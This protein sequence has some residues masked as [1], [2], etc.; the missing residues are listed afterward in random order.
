MNL[1]VQ[2]VGER[3][4]EARCWLLA[5]RGGYVRCVTA[6]NVTFACRVPQTPA[7][8]RLG[9]LD[10]ESVSRQTAM[11]EEADNDTFSARLI[12]KEILCMMEGDPAA[13]CKIEDRFITLA[14]GT[15]GKKDAALVDDQLKV[16]VTKV[17]DNTKWLR[18]PV[19]D[20]SKSRDR[21]YRLFPCCFLLL[22]SA[23]KKLDLN[24]PAIPLPYLT[25]ILRLF[26]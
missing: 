21:S 1:I 3:A 11:P 14:D 22:P 17:A 13:V 18:S 25:A 12:S 7:C 10:L 20:D 19:V 8:A 15:R 2:I 26:E 9:L 24:T 23:I 16:R 4:E 5:L 6:N